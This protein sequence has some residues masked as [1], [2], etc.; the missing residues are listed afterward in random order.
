[1]AS[2]SPANVTYMFQPPASDGFFLARRAPIDAQS[3]LC[4]STLRPMLF[5]VCA[6]IIAS[7]FRNAMSL[8]T[9]STTF[10]PL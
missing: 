5:M 1:M 2:N 3:M 8:G 6:A 10:S 9:S 4:A 7:A